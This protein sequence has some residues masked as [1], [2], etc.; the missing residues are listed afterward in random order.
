MKKILIADKIHSDALDELNRIKEFDV[1]VKT[2][3]DE[4]ALIETIPEFNAI[5][6]RSHSKITAPVLEAAKNLKIII[7]AG[8]GLDNIDVERALEKGI[9]VENTPKATAIS[10][11]EQ[12]FG[13]MLSTARNLGKANLSMKAHKWEKSSF[14]GIELYE[15]TLG[16]IGI[17]RIGQEVAKRAI[18]FGMKVLAHDIRDIKSDIDVQMVTLGELL[19]MS[20]IITLHIPLAPETHH[21]LSHREFAQMKK[22][23]ILINPSRGGVVDEEALLAALE[24]GKVRSAALDVFEKEPPTDFRLIDHENVI[25]TPHIGASANEGQRRSGM[26]VVQILRECF[27]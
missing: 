27:C 6:V 21:L 20:D 18:A 23:V 26:E 5:V 22:G 7:R 11:A 15:K 16:I 12:T 13:L 3:M 1:T 8:I 14:E 25:A 17:G 10:V 4:K 19:V 9:R 2:G 24:S